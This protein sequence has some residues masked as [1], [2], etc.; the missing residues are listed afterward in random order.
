MS[1]CLHGERVATV[2]GV[3]RLRQAPP[4][5]LCLGDEPSTWADRLLSSRLGRLIPAL[6]GVVVTDPEAAA[7]VSDRFGIERSLVVHIPVA[8]PSGPAPS[9]RER[10]A[11][12]DAIGATEG[13]VIRLLGSGPDPGAATA[14]TAALDAA[15][16]AGM[17]VIRAGSA[18]DEVL[19]AATDIAVELEPG[20]G[21]PGRDL[22][23]AARAGAALVAPARGGTAAL[24]DD[25]TGIALADPDERSGLESLLTDALVRLGD[26]PA[27]R[28]RLGAAARKRI[29]ERFD[30]IDIAARWRALMPASDG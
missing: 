7:T 18:D 21:G 4:V 22:L 25:T 17:F 11:A 27:L 26:D 2:A 3:S 5:L 30:I 12:R 23:D 24:V 9:A 20:R 10:G 19:R 6:A 1:S 13:A 29:G 28:A 14:V 16:G 8:I 15:R